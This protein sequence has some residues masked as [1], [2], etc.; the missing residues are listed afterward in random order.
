MN[1]MMTFMENHWGSRKHALDFSIFG[2]HFNF[3]V[4]A[5]EGD[6]AKGLDFGFHVWKEHT[7]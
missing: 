7:P 1:N 5:V 4:M 6:D 2:W 3:S